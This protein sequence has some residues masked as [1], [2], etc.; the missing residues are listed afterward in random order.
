[1]FRIDIMFSKLSISQK[2]YFSFVAIVI[3]IAVLVASA[4]RGFE[5]VE[6][7]T[8]NNVH[9]YQVLSD[10]QLA[11]EQLINIET[12][13]RGFV[14][15]SKDTFLEPLVAGQRRFA[16]ELD[17]LKRLTSDNAEQQR[18]LAT[19]GETQKRWM[20]EDI[21]PIIALRRDLTAR[22]MPDD[23]LD[24]RIT[25][26]ADKA[27][28][29]G[30][31]A[32]L[33]EISAVE[34]KLLVVR[35]Q[36]MVDAKHLAIMI[37]MCGGLAAAVLAGILATLL[38][39]STTARLQLAIDAATAIANGKLDTV[40][41]T[42]SHDELPKAFD[43]MQNRLREMIHQISQAANQL[44]VAVQQ[45]SGASEQLS[46]A[47]Q[48]QST[49]ASMMAATIEELTVSI[50]HVSENADEAHQL[51]SRSGQQSKDGAQVIESTLSSMNGIAKTVQLSSTQVAGLGQHSE[52]ISSIISVIQGIA[53]QT[54]LLALN[55]AI[56]AARAGEQGRGFAVVADEVRL[57]AQN[58]GKS[59]KEI[60]GMIEKIQAGVRE[61]VESMRSGVQEVNQ[62]VEMAGTAGQA[63]I[64]IRDSSSKVLQVVDQISFA[65]REQTV[66]S[67][68]VAR[69][70][71]RSAQM[72]EQNNM[73]VQELLKTS[74]GLKSLATSLQAE[75]GKFK[76]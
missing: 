49:S 6:D 18:R 14:I 34:N 5:Q 12:G 69:N 19:L 57:L 22:N 25:S 73:S 39:R 2:L 11:L 61:T 13:M 9:T 43:R 32:I 8:N 63:I 60:A 24:A 70:V 75:V 54:N 62:G 37:L 41:D 35:T 58:T 42:S 72:A 68:D 38:G 52:H 47:I 50:H 21:N 66:A 46:G 17:S 53:D 7:A 44:V 10:A 64:E 65:L 28:M 36:D 76:L 55:A 3:L 4:Y 33:S 27:K 30:M 20:D 15:A 26:G 16:E 71:E 40:I 67:Q 56:E 1:M 23:E 51:A 45:I 31:R 74:G 59:T 48:E 29:D